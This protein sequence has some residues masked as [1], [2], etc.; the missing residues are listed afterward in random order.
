MSKVKVRIGIIVKC[1]MRGDAT[2]CI[3]ISHLLIYLMA[4]AFI[5][6]MLMKL[7]LPEGRCVYLFSEVI[8]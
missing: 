3:V 1:G 5:M 2:L 6:I 8:M 4:G 7:P